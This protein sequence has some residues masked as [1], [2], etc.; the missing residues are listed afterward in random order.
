[1]NEDNTSPQTTGGAGKPGKKLWFIIGGIVIII[2]IVWAFSGGLARNAAERALDQAGIDVDRN[3][4]GSA[5]YT[6]D[7]GTVTVGSTSYP[8]NWPS[9]APKYPNG[10][11]MFSA[12]SNPQTGAA[13]ASLS[14]TTSDSPTAVI[15]FYKR[16]LTSQGWNIESTAS[17][18]GAMVLSATKD[19]R[20]LGIW[21]AETDGVTQ[22]TIGIEI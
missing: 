22:V 19:D 5:T 13:G 4:D 20:T 2:V 9:D 7:E 17:A 10:K 18:G 15:D 14:L 11:V 16:E 21:A 6:G 3:S 1:M 8:D 12:S